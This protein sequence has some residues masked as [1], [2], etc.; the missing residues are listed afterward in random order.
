MREKEREDAT[1]RKADVV[2][3]VRARK[4]QAED[5][6]H[7]QAAQKYL[8]VKGGEGGEGGEGGVVCFTLWMWCFG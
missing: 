7:R 2:E 6:V 4:A 5:K 3:L 1:R 8:Q